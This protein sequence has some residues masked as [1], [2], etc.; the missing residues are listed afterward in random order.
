MGGRNDDG[1]G[2]GIGEAL[3]KEL[4]VKVHLYSKGSPFPGV[5]PLFPSSA[6][7][8]RRPKGGVQ[9]GAVVFR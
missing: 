2:S 6:D 3:P 1:L 8:P 7:T 9:A 5:F 4:R